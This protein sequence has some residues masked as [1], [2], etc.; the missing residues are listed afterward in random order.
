MFNQAIIPF[1]AAT[2]F[3]A[4]N[5]APAPQNAA[6]PPLASSYGNYVSPTGVRAPSNIDEV[7]KEWNKFME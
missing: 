2:A 7:Q 4:P 1:L 5:Y 6:G 3:A